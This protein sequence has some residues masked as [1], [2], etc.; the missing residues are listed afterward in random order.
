VLLS[1]R[2]RPSPWD[3]EDTGLIS[4]FYRASD[5]SRWKESIWMAASKFELDLDCGLAN[6]QVAKEG[7][8]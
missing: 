3:K 1:I 2:S 5:C 8:M 4:K 6:F 7:A